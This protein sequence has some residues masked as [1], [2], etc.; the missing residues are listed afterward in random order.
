MYNKY[1]TIEWF[2]ENPWGD[3]YSD[4]KRFEVEETEKMDKFISDLA[5]KKGISKI[6]KN[7]F[8]EI[9]F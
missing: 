9:S 2:G 3:C 6:W 1:Y 4:R 8:E 5:H 7:T